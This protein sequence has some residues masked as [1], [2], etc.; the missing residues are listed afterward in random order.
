MRN[1]YTWTLPRTEIELGRRT[2]V[3]GIL[4]LT[5]DS[6]SDGGKYSKLES[7]VA[8][9][10]EIQEQGADI[11]DVGGESSRPGS[12]PVS[13]EE[14]LCRVMPIIEALA[15]KLR[16]P[17]SVDTYRSR[18][19]LRAME[20]GAQIINDISAFRFDPEMPRVVHQTRAG[21]VLMHS[22]GNRKQL[23]QQPP[24]GDAVA[25]VQDALKQAADIASDAGIRR[26]AVV[27][28]PGIGF[29]KSAEESVMVLRHL[30]AF[31]PL[32]YPLLIGTSR[33]SFLR[34]LA[35]GG[36]LTDAEFIRWGTA[37]SV[38]VAI[39]NGAHI[40]R[41]HD[42]AEMRHFVNVLDAL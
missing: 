40:V 23:H 3:M 25:E 33:K 26:S 32:E 31:T 9:A 12:V 42:V 14:E 5:P 38:A 20:A 13:E 24:M 35:L 16:I 7:A 11:L 10:L 18:V 21:I 39:A 15:Y 17:L 37:A 29:G 2:S 36:P 30:W 27:M 34:K 1:A 22:R 41:V 8:R 6:F 28:D 4:N 19:A